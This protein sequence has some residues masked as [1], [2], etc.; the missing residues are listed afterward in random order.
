MEDQHKSYKLVPL[1]HLAG[2]TFRRFEG[3]VDYQPMVD[4]I[5]SNIDDPN[6]H[7]TSLEDLAADYSHLSESVPER[8]MVFAFATDE[9]VAYCRTT[10]TWEESSKSWIYGWLMHVHHDWKQKGVEEAL[11]AWLEDQAVLNHQTLHPKLSAT[12]SAVIP[13]EDH[14][15]QDILQRR[16]YL[17]TRYF[18]NMKRDLVDIPDFPLPEGIEVRSAFPSQYR[19]VWDANVEAFQDH[20][21]ATIP[22]E[23]EYQEFISNK[24]VFQPYLWQ[25]AWDGEE[26]AGMVLNFIGLTENEKRGRLRGYTEN[27]CVRRPWRGKGIAKALIC[28]S[29][30]MMKSL[31]MT[32]VALGVDSQ[33]I[34]GAT[35]LYNDLGYRSYS[36][37]VVL[38][39]PLKG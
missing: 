33:N 7:V 18:E 27:I 4:I 38:R 17:P 2:F 6:A 36:R 22:P 3:P 19:Q 5:M 29:M 25:I 34:S 15:R 1:P 32:E 37:L 20:W 21:G 31:G 24:N 30:K 12:H 10:M 16:G 23:S 13:E 26:I 11:I 39:K 8:D 14:Y 35:K 9:P 28:R